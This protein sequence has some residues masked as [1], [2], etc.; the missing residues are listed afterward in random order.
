MGGCNNF[1]FS[2]VSQSKTPG[3]QPGVF[4]YPLFDANVKGPV[5]VSHQAF[6]R[7]LEYINLNTRY[8]GIAPRAAATSS[9]RK[10]EQPS[11]PYPHH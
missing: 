8:A 6:K 10:R 7:A 3:Y 4:L 2:A 9:V 5:M 1:R 11:A